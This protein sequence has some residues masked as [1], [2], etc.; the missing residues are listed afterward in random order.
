MFVIIT[1]LFS[2]WEFDAGKNNICMV[3]IQGNSF[4]LFE[5]HEYAKLGIDEKD[6]SHPWDFWNRSSSSFRNLP[7]Q[8]GRSFL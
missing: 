4:Q 7:L 3:D 5:N 8:K 1:Y 2:Q 6:L